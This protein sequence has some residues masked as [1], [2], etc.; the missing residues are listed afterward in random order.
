MDQTLIA[1]HP[2][3]K[4][5]YKTAGTAALLILL[6]GLV[7]A[8]TSMGGAAR[9]NSTVNIVEWFTLFQTNRFT[10]FSCLG[11]INI[12]TLS[13]DIPLYLAFN[14]VYRKDHSTLTALAS[15]LF[16]IGAAVYF[17]SN[18]VFS[19][20]ALSNQYAFASELQKPLLAAA[21]QALLA[22]GADLTSGT[23]FGLFITQIAG[24]LISS[25]M[26][27]G[28]VFGKWTG[29]AGLAGFSLMTIFF[30]LTAF[31]PEYY[32]SAMTIALPGA[33]IMLA[34]Q[35]MLARRFF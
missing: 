16:F 3:S 26:L 17:S 15:I 22:Q 13:L 6:V 20:F 1:A 12:I 33:L 32:A 34:Y 2:Y 7:D 10:A 27:K 28:N 11:V 31:A 19:L 8:L 18:T 24:L 35:I 14:Q 23:F 9:D 4:A 29:R 25:V 30:I 21:G 5:L